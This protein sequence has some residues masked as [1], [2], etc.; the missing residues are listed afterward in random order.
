MSG[1]VGSDT[2]GVMGGGVDLPLILVFA[3]TRSSSIASLVVP[4]LI[5]GLPP[6]GGCGG[7][8]VGI[9]AG[10]GGCGCKIKCIG[11]SSDCLTPCLM[12]IG[13]AAFVAFLMRCLSLVRALITVC[14]P[15]PGGGGGGCC[16]IAA[17][18]SSSPCVRGFALFFIV[19]SVSR[20]TYDGFA[21][22]LGPMWFAICCATALLFAALARS[23]SARTLAVSLAASCIASLAAISKTSGRCPVCLK[24]CCAIFL[25]PLDGGGGGPL[26]VE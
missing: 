11:A 2:F 21:D 23:F 5:P 3:R 19:S 14:P 17:I 8:C 20:A 18:S 12:M 24:I 7:G 13:L 22:E 16:G 15:A 9:G 1:P 26:V 25:A 6:P 4:F 10:I